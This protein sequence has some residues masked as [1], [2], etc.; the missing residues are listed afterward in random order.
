MYNERFDVILKAASAAENKK[1]THA[2]LTLTCIFETLKADFLNDL[3]Y[4]HDYI[5]K[6]ALLLGGDLPIDGDVKLLFQQH[7]TQ[8]ILPKCKPLPVEIEEIMVLPRIVDGVISGRIKL[9]LP[10]IDHDIAGEIVS[11]MSKPVVIE[12]TVKQEDLFKE[13]KIDQQKPDPLA[14]PPHHAQ[15]TESKK[16]EKKEKTK[17]VR[18]SKKD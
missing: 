2:A 10:D 4:S 18:K 14:L 13:A 17:K 7:D 16:T 5:K 1:P 11:K 12:L 6:M 3:V 8:L 15:L 9:F